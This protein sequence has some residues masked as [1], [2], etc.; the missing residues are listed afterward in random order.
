[1]DPET[2]QLDR[3]DLERCVTS[4]TAAIVLGNLFGFPDHLARLGEAGA[5]VIDD[6][7]Q[8]LG[9]SERGRTVGSRGALGVLSFGRGK[10]VSLGQGG[11]LLIN[12]P[13]AIEHSVG[14]A[15]R[16]PARGVA[17]WISACGV[18][19][20]SS[21]AAFGMLSRWPGVHV[22]ESR[23]PPPVQVQS[24]PASV[25]GMAVDLRSA[26][27]KQLEIRR[28]VAGW[29]KDALDSSTLAMPRPGAGTNPA[30]L[31][32]PVYAATHEQ[33]E[34]FAAKL[35]GAGFHYVRSYPIGLR[36]LEVLQVSP[37]SQRATPGADWIAKHLIALPCHQS[38]GDDD[39]RR[40]AAA[41][42][43]S[44]PRGVD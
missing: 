11:A 17:A 1:M 39:V 41:M 27:A 34:R 31:R 33:R 16:K 23:Y 38:V 5:L 26:V 37:H 43:A 25:H 3:E 7:A 15:A 12:G 20:S 14:S 4:S 10:C 44:D 36:Q 9:A 42:G 28:R 24:A 32:M 18:T 29:W 22:G 30:F 8:A 6:A 19:V 2:L 40:A 21:A 35:A 13:L